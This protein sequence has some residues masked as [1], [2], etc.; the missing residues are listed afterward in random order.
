MKDNE[1]LPVKFATLERAKNGDYF[2][3]YVF[4]GGCRFE[5]VPHTRSKRETAYF[6]AML[7]KS[8][9]MHND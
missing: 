1:L 6:Y 3:L 9:L 4:V 5:L 2:N 8:E 7:K